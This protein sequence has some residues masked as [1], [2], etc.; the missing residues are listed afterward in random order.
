MVGDD[1]MMMVQV[2]ELNEDDFIKEGGIMYNFIMFMQFID[3]KKVKVEFIGKKVGDKINVN[4]D[5]IMCGECDKVVLFG[6]FVEELVNYG[7]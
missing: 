3:D 6:I 2:V 5:D 7:F 4:I 1:D